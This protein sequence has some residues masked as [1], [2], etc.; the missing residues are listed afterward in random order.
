MTSTHI[1]EIW[2]PM[3]NMPGWATEAIESGQ[4]FT[5]CFKRIDRLTAENKAMPGWKAANRRLA[6]D[7]LEKEATIAALTEQLEQAR[8]R[9]TELE[10]S[11]FPEHR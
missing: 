7:L 6:D 3:D 11:W 4:L 1:T 8:T 2:P 9:I 5:E 10:T